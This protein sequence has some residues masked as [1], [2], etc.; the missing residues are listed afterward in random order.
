[1]R[2]AGCWLVLANVGCAVLS[3]PA[4]LERAS[5]A[6]EVLAC[7][8][9]F[10]T[11][12]AEVDHAG[13]RDAGATRMPGF[14]QLRV[15]RLIASLRGAMTASA[16]Q[17]AGATVAAATTAQGSPV[18]QTALVQRMQQLDAQARGYEIAN[19]PSSARLRLAGNANSNT[20]Q[21]VQRTQDCAARLSAFDLANP[22][23]MASLLARLSVPDD[24]TT[25]ARLLGLYALSRLPFAMGV[26]RHEAQRRAVFAQGA[27]PA[28][29]STRLRLS[30]PT[31]PPVGSMTPTRLA[32]ML[33]PAPNDPFKVPAPSADDLELL[34]AHYAPSFNI[35]IASNDDLPG[36]LAWQADALTVDTRLPVLYRQTAHTRYGAHT[37]LQLV[38]TL[39]FPARP[40]APGNPSDILSGA[41]DGLVFRVTLAPDG[42]PLVY[43]SMHPCGCYHEFYPTPAAQPIAAPDP[44]IEWAFSPQTLPTI[45]AQDQLVIRVAAGTHYIDRISVEPAPP[46]N[47]DAHY[48]WRAYDSLRSLPLGGPMTGTSAVNATTADAPN[49]QA[50]ERRSVFGPDGFIAGTDRA[51]RYLFWPMGIPRAGAMRQ[52]GHHATAFVGRRH[53][54]EAQLM[55]Q[56]FIFN[57]VHFRPPAQ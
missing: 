35:A 45:A 40:A 47:G 46:S 24:Y 52:W 16:G 23:R 18:E 38:Y 43:D 41:L 44:L 50:L 48:A 12:D 6:P 5:T 1:M 54:D 9:W 22:A 37:L 20:A 31:R 10:A 14:A 25:S 3:V 21:L 34:Y 11:L 26:R 51:E 15:D 17:G 19:L 36:A 39:W 8:D 55:E 56:R 33:A 4:A 27:Q 49:A 57:S 13:V 53:F 2:V 29:S 28:P 42:A 30:P 7:F 32:R